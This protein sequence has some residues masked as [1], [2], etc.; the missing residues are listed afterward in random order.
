M[1][2][3]EE[4]MLGFSIREGKKKGKW[5]WEIGF[6]P[7]PSQVG[8]EGIAQLPYWHQFLSALRGRSG[9][10]RLQ[11]PLHPRL[12]LKHNLAMNCHRNDPYVSLS[13]LLTSMLKISN[14]HRSGEK[15]EELR[16]L[17]TSSN[18]AFFF[19]GGKQT[20]PKN[21]IIY[22]FLIFIYVCSCVCSYVYVCV[23]LCVC[24]RM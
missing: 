8:C 23:F 18:A 6:D 5:G 12:L 2:A 7:G 10:G 1:T 24:T 17:K 21:P 19:S 4:L 9:C 22:Y 16:V 3:K 11:H 13:F 20:K 15:C 14:T